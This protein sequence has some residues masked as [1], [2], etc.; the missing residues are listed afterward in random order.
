[1][2]WLDIT[3]QYGGRPSHT[4]LMCNGAFYKLECSATKL[5]SAWQA[6]GEFGKGWGETSSVASQWICLKKNKPLISCVIIA[7]FFHKNPLY[8][9]CTRL[10]NLTTLAHLFTKTFVWVVLEFFKAKWQQFAPKKNA[11][12]YIVHRV[13]HTIQA[14]KTSFD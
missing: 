2:T 13:L 14:T 1:M 4:G 10:S 3:G 5:L 6:Y 8:E 7:T 11:P 12:T 9:L